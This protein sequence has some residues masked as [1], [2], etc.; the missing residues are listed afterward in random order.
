[1]LKEFSHIKKSLESLYS[2]NEIRTLIQIIFSEI[3]GFDPIDIY[4]GKDINLSANQQKEL[5]DIIVRLQNHEPIQYIT[6]HSLFYGLS[7]EVNSNVLIPRPETEELVDWI[8]NDNSIKQPLILDI[9]TGSG[10]IPIA[11]YSKLPDSSIYAWDI[12]Q[13]ALETARVNSQKHQATIHFKETDILNY[14]PGKERF[15]I[16]VSNPPYVTIEEKKQMDKNVLDWEP[17]QALFVSD[18]DPLLFYRIIGTLA[19]QMLLPEGKLFFE[20]NRTFGHETIAL[21]RGLGY[22]QIEIR[23]DISGNERMIKAQI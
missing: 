8:L 4:I 10:C 13:K 18:Q 12:S 23:K 3:L 7:L 22:S 1:M 15:D 17:Q 14:T 2:E 9:G 21:L 16:I 5:E 19:L 20:I 11:L 6:G